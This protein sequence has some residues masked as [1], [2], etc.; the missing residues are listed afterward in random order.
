MKEKRKIKKKIGIIVYII[1]AIIIIGAAYL[2]FFNNIIKAKCS[3]IE[4][5]NKNLISCRE[6]SY[7]SESSDIVMQYNIIGKKNGACNVDI[8]ILQ[9]KKGDIKLQDLEGNSMLCSLPLGIVMAPEADMKKCHGLLKE[10]IQEEVISRM[11]R[12]LIENIGQISQ[13]ISKVI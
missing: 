6:A 1:A 10:I 8:K 12:Q 5:F 7:I 3:D 11:H 4:C 13:N 2:L 9:V